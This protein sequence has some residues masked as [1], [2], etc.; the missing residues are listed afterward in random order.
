[1]YA[2]D[3]FERQERPYLGQGWSFPLRPSV[4]GGMQLSREAEKVRQS[5]GIILGT[6]LGERVYR[7]NFGCRLSELTFA[8]LNNS[9]LFMIRMH[10]EEALEAWEPRIVLQEV[11]TEPDP[12]WGIVSIIINYYLK[13]G[14]DLYSL[15]YPFYL[16]AATAE[17]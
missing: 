7:P 6:R 3:E 16:Q 12:I 1:M 11:R 5:I 17:E 2:E 13:T 4:Q 14:P 15:V 8:P 9:T 10:V